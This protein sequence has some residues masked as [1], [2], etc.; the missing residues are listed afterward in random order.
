MVK[1]WTRKYLNIAI[2]WKK[3]NRRK[4]SNKTN[5][6]DIIVEF[7]TRKFPIIR[8]NLFSVAST[9]SGAGTQSFWKRKNH[10]SNFIAKQILRLIHLKSPRDQIVNLG[11]KFTYFLSANANATFEYICELFLWSIGNHKLF[12][13]GEV[14]GA[15]NSDADEFHEAM[16]TSNMTEGDIKS[17]LRIISI[18]LYFR[19]KKFKK[20]GSDQKMD[21]ML[22]IQVQVRFYQDS[23][24]WIVISQLFY[25]YL[26]YFLW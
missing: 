8:N 21:S 16:N 4:I 1:L 7:W 24:F 23:F 6:I 26:A 13:F 18:S 12:L 9:K 10:N 11:N 20:H 5:L 25:F 2:L 17:T 14:R 22:L 15:G 19:N 3:S